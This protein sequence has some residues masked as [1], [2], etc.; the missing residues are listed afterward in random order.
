MPD[1]THRKAV[2][3]ALDALITPPPSKPVRTE[4]NA[5]EN[6]ADLVDKFLAAIVLY[7]TGGGSE[8]EIN[9][10]ISNDWQRERERFK[11]LYS[12]TH[13]EWHAGLNKHG[14]AFARG[15]TAHRKE[16]AEVHELFITSLYALDW[17]NALSKI[18]G[19]ATRVLRSLDEELDARKKAEE[20][21]IPSILSFKDKPPTLW[22]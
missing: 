1:Q 6:M 19:E 14:E 4:S 5:K 7:R 3:H 2:N 17:R 13:D 22:S 11:T 15:T 16:F 9:Y 8:N 12:I 21:K 18:S 10:G 20:A